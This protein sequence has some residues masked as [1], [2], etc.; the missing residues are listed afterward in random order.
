MSQLIVVQDS[1]EVVGLL[2]KASILQCLQKSLVSA[3]I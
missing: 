2:E 1:G 3:G